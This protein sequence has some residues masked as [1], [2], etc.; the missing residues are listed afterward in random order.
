[1]IVKNSNK[2]KTYLDL[3]DT[4]YYSLSEIA[5]EYT[6]ARLSYHTSMLEDAMAD[7][8]RAFNSKRSIAE[9]TLTRMCDPRLSMTNEAL[10]L[11]I[12]ELEK[13]VKMMKLGVVTVSAQP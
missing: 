12:E 7:M 5:A 3:T 9:I 6:M 8:Q 10:V 13:T 2:A 4:E 11:R 1:M